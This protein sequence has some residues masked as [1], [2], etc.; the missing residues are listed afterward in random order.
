MKG[1]W[2]RAGLAF[3]LAA[4]SMILGFVPPASAA[5]ANSCAKFSGYA[6]FNPPVPAG[7]GPKVISTITVHGNVSGCSPSTKTG[8]SGVVTGTI[9]GTK[10]GNCVTTVQGGNTQK[11]TSTTKW[12]NG[13]YSKFSVTVKEGTARTGSNA[14]NI[15]HITGTV[16]QGLFAGKQISGATKFTPANPGA[17]TS[18]PLKKVTFVQTTPLVLH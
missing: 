9:K 1:S 2:T 16:T 17:C 4:G 11:G 18:A 12:K 5:T 10:G 14:Y 6:T 8:G 3:A 7:N 15:A 13:K